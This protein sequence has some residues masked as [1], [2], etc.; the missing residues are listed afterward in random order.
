MSENFLTPVGRLVQGDCFAPQT[1]DQQGNLRVIKTGPNAGQPNPQFYVGVAFRK[2]DPM[3][4]AFWAILD[5]VAR[6]AWPQFFP[7]PGGQCTNP[8]FAFK[9]LDGDGYDTQ[10]RSNATKEG[11]AGHWVVRFTTAFAPKCFPVG[12][13]AAHDQITDPTLLRRGYYVRVAGT[14]K[15]NENPTNPGLF[16]NFDLVELAGYGPEIV[17][18][19]DANAVF[20]GQPAAALPPGASATPLAAPAAPA[21]APG[22]GPGGPAPGYPAAPAPGY[23]A[24]P[25]PAPGYPAAP[26]PAPGYPPAPAPA[27]G[28]PGGPTPAPAIGYP[29]PMAGPAPAPIAPAPAPA[30]VAPPAAPPQPVKALTA[31]AAA[32]HPGVAYEG[33]IAAGWTDDTLRAHGFLA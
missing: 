33:F 20:G 12:R 15:S 23:P 16:L 3:W 28:Y 10:G 14:V 22:P 19:P 18:G 9:V 11:F 4:P 13:Y 8:K 30:P 32:A 7:V 24:A 31:A 2:D 21:A 17:S 1:K 25:A 6:G 27:P 5:R 29:A 26:A